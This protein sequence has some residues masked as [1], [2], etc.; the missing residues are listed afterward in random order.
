MS[1]KSCRGF[2]RKTGSSKRRRR[3]SEKRRP[4]SPGT[5]DEIRVHRCGEGTALGTN[6]LPHAEGVPERLLRVATPKAITA[7]AGRRSA[8]YLGRGGSPGGSGDVRS[9]AYSG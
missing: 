3:F 6:A 4:S 7:R 2:A 5:T 9:P 1:A 8:G